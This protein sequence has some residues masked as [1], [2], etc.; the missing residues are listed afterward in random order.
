MKA[1]FDQM[2]VHNIGY[3]GISELEEIL[4]S[5]GLTNTQKEILDITTK[6]LRRSPG[7]N[8]RINFE[9]FLLILKEAQVRNKRGI[10]GNYL[11]TRNIHFED[12]TSFKKEDEPKKASLDQ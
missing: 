1:F 7:P 4:I 8:P 2:D 5:L 10:R 12:A 9:T 11:T 3:I 6:V